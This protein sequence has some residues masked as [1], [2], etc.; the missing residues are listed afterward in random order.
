MDDP[1][2]GKVS[3]VNDGFLEYAATYGYSGK[4]LLTWKASTKKKFSS[5]CEDR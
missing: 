1:A 2:H 5:E 3:Q 4:D